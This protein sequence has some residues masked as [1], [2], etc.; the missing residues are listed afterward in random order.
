MPEVVNTDSQQDVVDD[1]QD[2]DG[3][4]DARGR[5]TISFPYAPLLEGER[6]AQTLQDYGGSATPE[7]VAKVL[8]QKS[9]SGAF[10]QK[11]SAA[12]IFGLISTRPGQVSLSRL[13]RAVIDPEKQAG[14]RVEAFLN[15]PLYK[16]IFDKY[17]GDLLPPTQALEREIVGLGVSPKQA[18][19]ARQVMFRSA[20]QAGFFARGPNRLVAP[21]AGSNPLAPPTS[22]LPR[23][24]P[25]S[26]SGLPAALASPILALLENG[27]PWTPQQT[28][29][30]VDGLRKMF[31]ALEGV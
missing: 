22:P 15:V 16:T 13:G 4:S 17:Q 8:G 28:H 1:T 26:P 18:P 11:L 6:I 31:R 2:S 3:G 21:E 12:R 7:G 25:P 5:S 10:R 24:D 27:E 30:Y 9:G 23:P 20:E 19:T 14:A 29:D